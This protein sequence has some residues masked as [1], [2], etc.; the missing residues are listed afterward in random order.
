MKSFCLFILDKK[1]K[2]HYLFNKMLL[3]LK[4]ALDD[5]VVKFDFLGLGLDESLQNLSTRCVIF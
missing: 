3:E 4:L 2:N 1:I 5:S